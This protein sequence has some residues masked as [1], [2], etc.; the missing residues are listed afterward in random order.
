METEKA[1]LLRLVHQSSICSILTVWVPVKRSAEI[2]PS[3]I[4]PLFR[5]WLTAVYV[6]A[7]LSGPVRGTSIISCRAE[8][9]QFSLSHPRGSVLCFY[10]LPKLR[11]G[12]RGPD[13]IVD[14]TSPDISPGGA[15]F[16]LTTGRCGQGNEWQSLSRVGG[17]DKPPM[18][19]Q[20][21]RLLGIRFAV[22][23]SPHKIKLHHGCPCFHP[24][25]SLFF[26]SKFFR[27]I[28]RKTE[29]TGERSHYF[30]SCL[31]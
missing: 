10:C 2:F 13:V 31:G 16:S 20:F 15:V 17:P 5:E 30:C 3:S 4:T 1:L 7:P 11:V 6:T 26:G 19:L 29:Y 25:S 28:P 8:D 21:L 14:G 24:P 23:V 18:C 27:M 22:V 9:C 12:L